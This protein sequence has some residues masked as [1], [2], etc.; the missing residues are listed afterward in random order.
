[1]SDLLS[2]IWRE[3][4]FLAVLAN[5]GVP[6]EL[7]AGKGFYFSLVLACVILDPFFISVFCS[8]APFY[9]RFYFSLA[10][11]CANLDSF[12]FQSSAILVSFLF[13][14]C[15]SLRHLELP[16]HGVVWLFVLKVLSVR[17]STVC[18]NCVKSL[19]SSYLRSEE[20]FVLYRRWGDVRSQLRV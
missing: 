18:W 7:Y 6:C 17:L 2:L 11:A 16:R 15:A 14:S 20:C 1:M 3:F 8:P 4:R 12:L 10:L 13:Q 9:T 19:M 5:I